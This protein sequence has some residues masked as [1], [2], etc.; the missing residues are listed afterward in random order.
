MSKLKIAV[1]RANALGDF[2]FA[3]PALTALRHK[4]PDADIAY[5][6][7]PLHQQL[8]QHRPLPFN[9]T[10]VVP[11]SPGVRDQHPYSSQAELD[12]FFANMQQEKF[13]LAIQ[14]H[15]GGKN[16]NPFLLKL[17]AATTYGMRTPDAVPLDYT[18]PY[19]YYQHE[20]LRLLD[21]VALLEAPAVSPLPHLPVTNNDLQQIQKLVDINRPYIVVHPG[22]SDARRRWSPNHF[23]HVIDALAAQYHWPI[24]LTG[25]GNEQA[26][27]STIEQT[28]ATTVTNLYQQLSISQ[29]IGLYAHAALVI[30]N[31]TGPLHIAR[32]A[33]TPNVGIYWCGNMINAGPVSTR[34]SRT[35]ISWT[36]NCQLCHASC[37]YPSFADTLTQQHCQHQTSFVD[38]IS[39][40]HVLSLAM[41]LLSAVS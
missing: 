6:G 1:L 14:L 31:D 32:S 38:E 27:L 23:S 20:V 4:F 22:A 37:T 28:T 3:L 19:V 5:L 2:I 33:G 36:V 15:G 24:F 13:D 7:T 26:A 9:R 8:A 16:S 35:A 12:N 39:S 29:L 17:G 21:A 18:I 40:D 25:Q 34:N 10:I 41:E 30:S 11:S